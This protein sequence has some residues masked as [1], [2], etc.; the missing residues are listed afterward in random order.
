MLAHMCLNIELESMRSLD[1]SQIGNGSE[2][3]FNILKRARGSCNDLIYNG[4]TFV[5]V[6]TTMTW[7][8]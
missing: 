5:A 1:P 2:N 7:M 3:W 4:H 6:L 8:V